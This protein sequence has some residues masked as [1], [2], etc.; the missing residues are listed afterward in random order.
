MSE[1]GK[2]AVDAESAV[3]SLVHAIREALACGITCTNESGSVL[4]TSQVDALCKRSREAMSCVRQIEQALLSSL[5]QPESGE[6]GVTHA[7]YH[8]ISS[9][10]NSRSSCENRVSAAVLGMQ[11]AQRC[12][13]WPCSIMQLTE[14]ECYWIFQVSKSSRRGARALQRKLN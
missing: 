7:C 13:I 12:R 14:C 1:V 5:E 11:G 10:V 6:E 2:P 8:S 9:V 4:D 3:H